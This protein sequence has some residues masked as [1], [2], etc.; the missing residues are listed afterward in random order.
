MKILITGMAGFIGMHLAKCLSNLG[1]TIIGIDNLSDITYETSLKLDRLRS[2]GINGDFEKETEYSVDNISFIKLSI[3]DREKLKSLVTSGNFDV[4]VNLAALAGVRLSTIRPDDYFDVNVNGFFNLLEAI[5]AC[6]IKPHLLFASSSSVYGDCNRV[7]FME[8]DHDILPVSVYAATK[9]MNESIAYT[10]SRLYG[11]NSIGLRFFTVYGPWGRP[12]MAPFIFTKAILSGKPI[13]LFNYGKL[14]RDFTYVDDIVCGIVRMIE[15]KP[16]S[17]SKLP[18]EIYNIG[19]GSPIELID[20]IS[21]LEKI[22]GKK[23]ILNPIAMQ[24]G[25]VHQTFAD[26]TKLRDDYAYEAKTSL[27]EGLTEFYY[28]FKSYY[29]VSRFN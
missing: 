16:L 23:A 15:N 26:V 5:R 1:H 13:N 12:D 8:S 19:H 14:R 27:S 3:T 11:F 22:I 21:S 10:Y 18:F 28:W 7:P 17:D 25:D 2:L 9:S 29:D 6:K 24:Q 20:F 4:I